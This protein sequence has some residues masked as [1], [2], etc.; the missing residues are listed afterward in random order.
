MARFVSEN[1]LMQR[2]PPRILAPETRSASLFSSRSCRNS[3][4]GSRKITIPLT[5]LCCRGLL[6]LKPKLRTLLAPEV[7]PDDAVDISGS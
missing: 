2:Y 5:E 6:T 1:H 7:Y 4:S 3:W